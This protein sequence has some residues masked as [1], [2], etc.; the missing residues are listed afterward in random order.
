MAAF[1]GIDILVNNAARRASFETIDEITDEEWQSTF[2]VNIHAMF[3]LTN[4]AVARMK[5]GSCIINTASV[6]ADKPN[7]TLLAYAT[8]KGAIQSFTGGLAQLAARKG[9]RANAVAPR[10]IWAPLIPSTPPEGSI[11]DF[12]RQVPMQRPR[13]PAELATADVMLDHCWCRSPLQLCLRR[14]D[15]RDGRASDPVA[16]AIA[17]YAPPRMRRGRRAMAACLDHGPAGSAGARLS[18]APPQPVL[19]RTRSTR[20]PAPSGCERIWARNASSSE[21][22]ATRSR[23]LRLAA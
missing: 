11:R 13:Q 23:P 14:D 2:A 21:L 19:S 9:I 3:Y 18:E 17:A 7:P 5:P 1:G 15:R 20:R 10:P 12:G 4:A 22:T 16:G 6:N 8:A